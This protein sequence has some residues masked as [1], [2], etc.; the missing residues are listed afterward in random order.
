MHP[1][2]MQSST[3]QD[4]SSITELPDS[5]L[6]AEQLL[7]IFHRYQLASDLVVSKRVLE[8]ACGAGPGLGLLAQKAQ[9]LVAVDYSLSVLQR[10]KAHY[11]ARFPLACS[12]AQQLPF[13]SGAFDV[14]LCFEAIYYLPD[15]IHFLRE[16]RRIVA[17]GGT[18]LL[19]LSNPN[20]PYFV[21]GLMTTHYPTVPELA[22]GLLG[23]GFKDAQLFGILPASASTPIGRLRDYLRRLALR[24]NPNASTAPFAQ[25]LK[26][27]VYRRALP[28]P[29][30]LIPDAATK[31]STDVKMTPLPLDRPD[32][33]HRVLYA[34]CT[35]NNENRTHFSQKR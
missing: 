4:Y 22:Q 13:P 15:Y 7:R 3:I 35:D 18:L 16:S 33:T 25:A 19:S 8:V 5:L 21:P 17:P 10:A 23:A 29:A 20:W 26:R 27:L 6:S 14:V 11:S 9:Q 30:E 12:D 32:P 2:Q 31:I 34:L 24:V 28:M 1:N